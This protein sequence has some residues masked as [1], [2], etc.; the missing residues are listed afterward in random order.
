MIH[1]IAM[2]YYDDVAFYKTWNILQCTLLLKLIAKEKVF[3]L[4]VQ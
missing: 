3:F 2:F 1:G 4:K